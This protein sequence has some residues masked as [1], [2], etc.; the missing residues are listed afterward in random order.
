MDSHAHRRDTP[1]G[2]RTGDHPYGIKTFA[3][4]LAQ[5]VFAGKFQLVLEHG[6]HRACQL[7]VK[8][9]KLLSDKSRL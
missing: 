7:V 1:R 9:H 5:N 6:T 2:K 8:H 4:C 3:Y